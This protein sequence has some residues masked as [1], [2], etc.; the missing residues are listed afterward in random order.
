MGVARPLNAGEGTSMGPLD[1]LIASLKAPKPVYV[2]VGPE[3][4]VTRELERLLNL[5]SGSY[6]AIFA[7]CGTPL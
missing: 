3:D 5:D 7:T 4:D 1:P 6:R 2:L